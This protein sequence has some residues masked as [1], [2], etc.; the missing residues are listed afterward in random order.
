MH[1]AGQPSAATAAGPQAEGRRRKGK[2][3]TRLGRLGQRQGLAEALCCLAAK[4]LAR[5]LGRCMVNIVLTLILHPAATRVTAPPQYAGSPARKA[6]S[7]RH[8]GH[9]TDTP[10]IQQISSTSEPQ[11]VDPYSHRR[12]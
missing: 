2:G 1:G 7:P 4:R 3:G 5:V 8:G 12:E 10:R 9:H 11:T 6:S